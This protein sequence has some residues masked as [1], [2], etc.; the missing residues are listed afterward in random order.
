MLKTYLIYSNDSG[1]DIYPIDDRTSFEDEYRR[2]IDEHEDD[3]F[4]TDAFTLLLD[5]DKPIGADRLYLPEKEG[6][7][8]LDE[9]DH[10]EKEI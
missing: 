8:F 4:E 1:V 10:E 3:Y 6:V 2:Q 5:G 7:D 9:F